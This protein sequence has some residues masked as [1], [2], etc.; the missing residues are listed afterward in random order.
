MTEAGLASASV[1]HWA[2]DGT[3]CHNC[4]DN[5]RCGVP[6]LSN[7]VQK[8]AK[9]DGLGALNGK[10]RGGHELLALAT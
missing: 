5:L 8:V 9:H 2:F 4:I 7:Q 3:S 1:T 10:D 6:I